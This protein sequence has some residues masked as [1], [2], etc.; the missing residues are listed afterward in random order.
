MF[1]L[2]KGRRLADYQLLLLQCSSIILTHVVVGVDVAVHR[3]RRSVAEGQQ[4]HIN[5]EH[6]VE[7]RE[8]L[9]SVLEV[10]TYTPIIVQY[11]Q[12]Y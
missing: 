5:V 11:I 4:E 3:A 2:Q 9:G 12:Y 1:Q 6:S 10:S 7:V 8:H